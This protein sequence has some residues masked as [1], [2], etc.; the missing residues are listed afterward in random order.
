M[1]VL[2][3]CQVFQEDRYLK[4]AWDCAELIWQRGLLRKGYG[5]CHGTAGNAYAF[6]ALYKLTQEKKHLYRS[7]K[8]GAP[9]GPCSPPP[10]LTLQSW[11]Y[12]SAQTRAGVMALPTPG[13]QRSTSWLAH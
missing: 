8:V 1:T 12:G 13:L 4:E 7:C 11:T 6:L 2:L 10:T 5:I 3:C 9:G